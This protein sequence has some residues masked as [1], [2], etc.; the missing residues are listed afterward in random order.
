ME[1]CRASLIAPCPH[2]A[3]P[4][5]VL[6]PMAGTG[7][8]AIQHPIQAGE[9]KLVQGTQRRLVAHEPDGGGDCPQIANGIADGLEMLLRDDSTV[10]NPIRDDAAV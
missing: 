10:R 4:L 9:V 3:G 7:L 1:K 6:W 5:L 8:A 2:V